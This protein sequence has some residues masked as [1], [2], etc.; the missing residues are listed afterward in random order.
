[1]ANEV[2]E[3]DKDLMSTEFEV[4]GQSVKLTSNTVKTFL[5]NGNGKITDQ[6]ALMFISLCKYQHLNPFLNE[7]YLVKFGNSPAQQIVSK[8][9]FMKRAESNSEYDGLKAGCIVQRNDDIKYTK[10]AFTLDTDKIL[11]GWAEVYRK[12][13]KEPIHIEISSREFSKGQA[14][15]KQ[16]PANMIRKTAIVNA[17]R[18]A[19]PT[20]LG[21]MYTE[22]DANTQQNTSRADEAP[23]N[24]PKKNLDD[25]VGNVSNKPEQA[26][27]PV[28][29]VTPDPVKESN[30]MSDEEAKRAYDEIK[31]GGIDDDAETGKESEAESDG[32]TDLFK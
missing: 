22:D 26:D 28:K 18:E 21:A 13:R 23:H 16:M 8:D 10:G 5:A 4:N 20:D 2:K 7:A 3:K 24:E 29:D 12:D 11:G 19:F 17:L 14:T 15:W 1:M 6:E 30:S 9:A 27:K 31:N 32:Q 25:L